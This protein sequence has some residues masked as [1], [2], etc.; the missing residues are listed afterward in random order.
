VDEALQAL[1]ALHPENPPA[2]ASLVRAWLLAMLG[3]FEEAWSLAEKAREWLWE[4]TGAHWADWIPAAIANLEGDHEA[5]VRYLHPFCDLL[6]EREQR[7]YL[8]SIAPGLG[9]ELCALGRLDEGERYAQLA[10]DLDVRQNVLGQ[11]TWRQVQALV[12]ANRDQVE[13]AE[14]L[15]REA[16]EIIE[17]TDGLNYQGDAFCDLAEVLRAAGRTDEA[18]AALEQALE[19]YERKGNV[20][21]A[22]RTRARLAGVAA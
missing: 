9:R 17:A 13:Q 14:A 7:F 5:A 2:G 22:E 19:R 12:H 1:D 21:M 6:E 20:V 10:R 8:S 3:R 11:A 16:V 15:V 18:T 4:L